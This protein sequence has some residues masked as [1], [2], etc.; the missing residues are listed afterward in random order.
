MKS[1]DEL[2][3][4]IAQLRH[5]KGW[6]QTKL[7]KEASTTRSMVGKVEVGLAS[8]SAGWIGAVALALGTD[9]ARLTGGGEDDPEKLHELVP[10][11]RRA[12]AAVDLVPYG[13][14]PRPIDELHGE[15]VKLGEWRRATKYNKIGVVLPDLVNEL[16]AASTDAGEPAYALLTG[17]YRAANT[18]GH[19]LGYADLSLTAVER[20][21]WA[22]ARS[23]DP[24]LVGMTHYLRAAAL[25]R[26]GA[27]KQAMVLLNRTID[28][29]QPVAPSDDLA[30]AVYSA[31]HM[32]AGT[33]AATLA[34]HDAS[35]SHLNE[36]AEFAGADRV[37][38]ETV[39]GATNVQLHR[40]AA[41]VDLGE[42]GKAAEIASSTH[43]PEGYARE[44]SAYFWVD[45]ARAYLGQGDTDKA[46]EALYEAKEVSKEHFRASSTVKATIKTVAAQ[47][48]R[49][50][51]GNLRA[52][53]NSAGV[54][55]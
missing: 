8:P 54:P 2:G 28:E 41:A 53:A 6:S 35:D 52:L 26:I 32:K 33:I 38:Y 7:A 42:V 25:A 31:L 4:R 37:V 11:I 23:G 19:K 1:S 21:E 20:M 17:A 39:V 5:L 16:L 13:I 24:L 50:G 48:R 22:A 15:V 34:D 12:L 51:S 43:L 40:L 36:A 10:T 18:L 46:I 44:R 14:E 55:D 30:S 45:T 47:E 3:Q 49:T 9:S 27:G 29:L